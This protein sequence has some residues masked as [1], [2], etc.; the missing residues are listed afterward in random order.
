MGSCNSVDELLLVVNQSIIDLSTH[1]AGCHDWYF[2]EQLCLEV[3][4]RLE[5]AVIAFEKAVKAGAAATEVG[6]RSVKV[7]RAKK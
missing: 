2:Y 4:E 6:A 3:S 7:P 1:P 5:E